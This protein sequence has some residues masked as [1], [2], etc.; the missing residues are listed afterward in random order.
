MWRN[1]GM[2]VDF[3]KTAL[4]GWEWITGGYFS[5]ILVGVFTMM[6]YIKYHKV[7]YPILIGIAFLPIQYFIFPQ[8]FTNFAFIFVIAAVCL[9]VIYIFL[10]QTKEYSG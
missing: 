2:D 9:M 3:L 6:S 4:L 8:S 10:R 7:I 1:C 5:V